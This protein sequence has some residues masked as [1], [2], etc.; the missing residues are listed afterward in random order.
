M[1]SATRSLGLLSCALLLWS[2]GVARSEEAEPE[3]A[4]ATGASEQR[5]DPPS[6]VAERLVGELRAMKRRLAARES[7]LDARERA[8]VELE[9]EARRLLQRVE[10][11]RAALDEQIAEWE[12]ENDS[13]IARLAKVYA[14]MPPAKAAPLVEGLDI[15]LATRLLTRMKHK[16]SAQV[17]ALL[18]NE[19]AL[20]LS[21]RVAR[22]L[23][24]LETEAP[25]KPRA[26]GTQ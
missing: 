2:A 12:Q 23:S 13:R 21:R 20:R 24:G 3:G 10:R 4:A 11:L 17:M 16:D 14:E 6:P 7:E 15:D 8:A 18:P 26:G 5:S 22:P 9:A 1:R 25:Q 19:V